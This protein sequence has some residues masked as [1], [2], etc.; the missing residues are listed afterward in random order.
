MSIISAADW[1]GL[2][3]TARVARLTLDALTQQGRPGV[4][5]GELDAMAGAW[6]AHHEHTLVI[7]RGAPIVLT[8]EPLFGC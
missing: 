5:T 4:T 6:S 2:Q 1:D 8:G 7:T 3:Q